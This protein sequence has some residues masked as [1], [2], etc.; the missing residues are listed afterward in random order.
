MTETQRGLMRLDNW[1]RWC[2]GGELAIIMRHYYPRRAAVAGQHVSSEVWD[3][4]TAPMPIDERDAELVEKLIRS[5]PVNL[6]NAVRNRYTGRPRI[7]GTPDSWLD[8]WVEHAA[9]EI[10]AKKFH[11]IP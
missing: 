6:R 11:V 10:M 7:I 5:M 2:C 9:R 4:D 3:D 1:A 8:Q